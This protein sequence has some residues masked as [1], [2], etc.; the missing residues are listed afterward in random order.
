MHKHCSRP[1]PL[2]CQTHRVFT[3]G[4]NTSGELGLGY[5]CFRVRVPQ[6]IQLGKWG[7]QSVTIVVCGEGFTVICTNTGKVYGW[8]NNTLL[9]VKSIICCVRSRQGKHD[10]SLALMH[11]KQT[12][13]VPW[14]FLLRVVFVL[15]LLD[16]RTQ[17]R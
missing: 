12:Y 15:W 5:L 9:Q 2:N 6:C 17:L 3:F 4:N 1:S 7:E 14:R 11:R 10:L 13:I 16:R 8:G